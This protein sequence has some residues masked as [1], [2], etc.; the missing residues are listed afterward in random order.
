MALREAKVTVKLSP[1]SRFIVVSFYTK[2]TEKDTEQRT[3][4]ATLETQGLQ[5]K[6]LN[7]KRVS[8]TTLII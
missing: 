5:K 2:T 6:I 3:D 7:Q 1:A 4:P 8:K